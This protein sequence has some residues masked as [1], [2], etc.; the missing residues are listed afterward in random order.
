MK[1]TG[2]HQSAQGESS[3]KKDYREGKQL[4]NIK[5]LLTNPQN[6]I[7]ILLSIPFCYLNGMR[8]CGFVNILSSDDSCGRRLLS[9]P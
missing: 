2:V 3:L 6:A 8:A 5:V 4:M 7:N 1:A 9:R